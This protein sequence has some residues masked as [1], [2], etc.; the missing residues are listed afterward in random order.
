MQ[1]KR[2]DPN[3][4]TVEQTRYNDTFF[5]I[6]AFIFGNYGLYSLLHCFNIGIQHIFF[7]IY[8]SNSVSIDLPMVV[9]TC[10]RWYFSIIKGIF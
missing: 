2:L 3:R 6:I 7:F 10:D 8:L 4:I 5:D 1:T 9:Y